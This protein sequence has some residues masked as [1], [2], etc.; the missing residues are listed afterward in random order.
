MLWLRASPPS[1]GQEYPSRLASVTPKFRA[2]IVSIGAAV[3]RQKDT[4]HPGIPNGAPAASGA[5][6]VAR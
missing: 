6:R 2:P 5:S 1:D 4:T 3:L